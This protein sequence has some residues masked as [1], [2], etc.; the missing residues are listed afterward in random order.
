MGRAWAVWVT[1]CGLLAMPATAQAA[2]RV[3]AGKPSSNASN[4]RLLRLRV[5]ITSQKAH[6]ITQAC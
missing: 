5:T 3:G 1:A 4:E 2:G 6:K